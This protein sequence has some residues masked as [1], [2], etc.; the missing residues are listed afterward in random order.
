MNDRLIE[1]CIWREARGQTA[2]DWRGVYS[3]LKN[4][5]AQKYM[6]ANT[7]AEVILRKYQF[8]SFNWD[9]TNST[10]FP[11]MADVAGWQAWSDIPRQC[12]T[13]RSAARS[14][15]P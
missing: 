2:D 10:K 12:P 4:R 8:S 11:R 5:L 13:Y 7:M 3:V 6:G 1:L 14:G 9:D 15:I